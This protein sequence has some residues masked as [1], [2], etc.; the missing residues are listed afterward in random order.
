M[1]G[2]YRIG[3][4][5]ITATVTQP[6]NISGGFLTP[7]SA[8]IHIPFTHRVLSG[9][10]LAE[11]QKAQYILSFHH[12]TPLCNVYTGIEVN[13]QVDLTLSTVTINPVTKMKESRV[14]GIAR[15]IYACQQ[16]VTASEVWGLK[17]PETIFYL[18]IKVT[19]DH[20]INGKRVRDVSPVGGV[21]RVEV[22]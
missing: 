11:G 1:F 10:I 15:K 12:K 21:Y 7:V 13:T 14:Q 22:S 4:K 19:T 17:V 18:P 2:D 16:L 3:N 20:F 6:K 9:D 8:L 5:R